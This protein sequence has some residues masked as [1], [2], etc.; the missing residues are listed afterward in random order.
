M[1]KFDYLIVGGGLA[2]AVQAYLHTFKEDSKVAIIEKRPHIGGFCYTSNEHGIEV[3]RYG[4]HI[5]RTDRK[6]VWDFVNGIC[7]FVPFVNSPVANYRGELFNLPFNMNTF[8]QL[9]GATSP[10]EAKEAIVADRLER[11]DGVYDNMED[12]VLAQ[13]GRKMYEKLI[14]G[15]SEK[16]WGRPC[17]QLPPDTMAHIPLR[18]TFDNNYYAVTYQGI[19]KIGYTQFLERMM[20]KSTLFLRSDF[21]KHRE[22]W[23]SMAR[24]II[25]T[26]CIDEY[27]GYCFGPLEYRSV[28]F[29]HKWL[30]TCDNHQGVAVMNFTDVE[31]AYTRCIEHKHFFRKDSGVKGTMLSFE[32]PS[33]PDKHC[34]PIYPVLD[35]KNL[36]LLARYMEL[37]DKEECVTFFGQLAEYKPYAMNELIEKIL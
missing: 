1:D 9:Y 14:K 22:Y 20:E 13:C 5:F 28:R 34:A 3:H 8:Y 25:Y 27:F 24:H 12:V 37:A 2:G 6:D 36:D 35:K 17:S 15:Y 4:A 7:E 31:P 32:Y 16:Q 18:M 23:R 29:E 21:N 19:P 33:L 10:Q 26:G 30:P 11:V